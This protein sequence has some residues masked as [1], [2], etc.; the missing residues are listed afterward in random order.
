MQMTPEMFEWSKN[1]WSSFVYALM[2]RISPEKMSF[3]SG[4]HASPQT[5]KQEQKMTIIRGGTTSPGG[6]FPFITSD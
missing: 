1:K 6:L 4:G 3:F 5:V 2:F